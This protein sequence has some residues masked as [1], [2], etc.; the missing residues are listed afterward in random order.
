MTFKKRSEII[1]DVVSTGDGLK[2]A[3]SAFP[4][5]KLKYKVNLLV[6]NNN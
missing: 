6:K 5:R 2:K 3:G 1:V 4:I